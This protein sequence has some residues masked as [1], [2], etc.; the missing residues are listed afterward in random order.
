MRLVF[1]VVLALLALQEND[2]AGPRRTG[3]RTDRKV[4]PR[5]WGG[6][7]ATSCGPEG[8]REE[9]ALGAR[10]VASSVVVID[11][12]VTGRAYAAAVPLS[13]P[14][15]CGAAFYWSDRLRDWAGGGRGNGLFVCVL[16]V[17]L[18]D[19]SAPRCG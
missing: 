16:F 12:R 11:Q 9:G 8:G 2:G 13:S 4:G 3:G 19:R 1:Q 15:S 17:A 5:L 6:A 10:L 18:V 7:P 14:S